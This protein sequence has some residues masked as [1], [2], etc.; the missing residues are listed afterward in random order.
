MST[1]TFEELIALCCTVWLLA[2][3]RCDR[4]NLSSSTG[5]TSDKMIKEDQERTIV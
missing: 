1:A 5:V 3:P 4:H 2:M